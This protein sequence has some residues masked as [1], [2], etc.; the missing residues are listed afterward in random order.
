[1]V[2]IPLQPAPT[3]ATIL[4]TKKSE[5]KKSTS[6]VQKRVHTAATA[7]PVQQ[8]RTRWAYGSR[9]LTRARGAALV[10][11]PFHGGRPSFWDRPSHALD[12]CVVRR[13]TRR[14]VGQFRS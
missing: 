4:S 14:K 9:P 3:I 2:L 5:A 10:A 6:A 12:S 11:A 8:A 7:W 13:N 1:M